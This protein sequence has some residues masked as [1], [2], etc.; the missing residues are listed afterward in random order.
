MANYNKIMIMGNLT[1]DPELSYLPN[2]TP[3]CKIGMASNRRY[4][5]QDGEQAEETLFI[6]CTAFGKQAEILNQYRRKGQPLFIEGR[7]KLDRWQDKEG[8]NRS[9]HQIVIENFQF[10]ESRASNDGGGGGGGG[11][12]GGGGGGGGYNNQSNDGYNSG[13]APAGPP[14]GNDED[15]PF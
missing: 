5:Q 15:I 2:N 3:V 12:N 11:Y 10:I 4:R 6:D 1:R 8:N 7:L 14:V 13:S 9:K